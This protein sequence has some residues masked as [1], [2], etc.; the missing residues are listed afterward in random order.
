MSRV[1]LAL[2]LLACAC[3][4][5]DEQTMPHQEGSADDAGV[6]SGVTDPSPYE[7]PEGSA[8]A[9][10]ELALVQDAVDA[11]L[12]ALVAIHPLDLYGAVV[13]AMSAEQGGC[14]GS[15][16]AVGVTR[17]WGNDCTTPTG[18]GFSGRSQFAW[19]D[20]GM[21]E[22]EAFARYGE[23]ITT[24]TFTT[25]DGATLAIE[26]YGDYRDQS[27]GAESTITS[28]FSGTFAHE[29]GWLDS[30][31]LDDGASLSLSAARTERPGAVEVVLDGGLSRSGRLPAGIAGVTARNLRLVAEGADCTVSGSVAVQ[32]QDG[33]R[34]VVPLDGTDCLACGDATQAG[35]VLGQVCVDAQ[36]LLAVHAEAG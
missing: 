11:G 29:G 36:V 22:G 26:G 4:G 13:E 31:W 6:D 9:P 18:W 7:G 12:L 25:P 17:G 35:A 27:G 30:P 3:A 34:V 1:A 19:L 28:W 5:G 8:P 20:P 15:Y 32:G 2:A 33:A 16:D 24:A 14:P 23:F 10:L 21:V